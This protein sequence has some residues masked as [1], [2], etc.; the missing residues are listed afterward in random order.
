[1]A[2]SRDKQAFV[3]SGI[4]FSDH[5]AVGLRVGAPM[6]GLTPWP[7]AVA[8]R[9]AVFTEA[10]LTPPPPPAQRDHFHQHQ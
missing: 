8:R 2:R 10:Q 4:N 6:S 1:M 7:L 5:K 3:E 9:V